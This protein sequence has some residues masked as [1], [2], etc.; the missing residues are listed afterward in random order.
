MNH[1]DALDWLHQWDD[2]E[3]LMYALHEGTPGV[4]MQVSRRTLRAGAEEWEVLYD[5]K[6]ADLGD[7]RDD[8]T[9]TPGTDAWQEQVLRHHFN[10][11]PDLVSEEKAYLEQFLAG[12]VDSD[13][14]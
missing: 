6:I 2:F 1:Y 3:M 11:H 8:T 10:Q 4:F 12:E 14:P 7:E 9:E 13:T 5:R